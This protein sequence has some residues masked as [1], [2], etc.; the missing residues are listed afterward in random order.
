[1]SFV[2]VCTL[3]EIWEG[4]MVS[5]EVNGQKILLVWPDGDQVRAF[6]GV[7][8][9]QN[10]SLDEGKFDGKTVM[11]RAHQWTFDGCT[12]QGINPGN[13][14]LAEYPVRLDGD[15]VHVNTEGILPLFAQV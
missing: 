4:D 7:C 9:H 15:D 13:C 3:E 10:I 1:M 5:F 6:Q 12:G 11:C 14:R 8:P 2:K